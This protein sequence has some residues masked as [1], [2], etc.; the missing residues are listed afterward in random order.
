MN[1][2]ATADEIIQKLQLEPHP[3]GGYFK[4]VYRSDAVFLAKTLYE[5]ADGVRNYGTLI[6]YLLK[7]GEFSAFHRLRQDE[8]FH[9]YSGA[10]LNVHTIDR[11]GQHQ[12]TVLGS[13]IIIDR[14]PHLVFPGGTWF[15]AA[16]MRGYTEDF[17]LIGCTCV[18]GF[19]YHDWELGKRE[20]LAKEFPQFTEIIQAFTRD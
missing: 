10:P 2:T 11:T 7:K 4:E 15:A 3:E 19:D 17:S 12:S 16:P 20:A 6:Y 14:V 5:S 1:S 9:F 18:P 8:I 13:N